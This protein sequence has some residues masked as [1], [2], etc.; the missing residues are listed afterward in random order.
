MLLLVVKPVEKTM[1]KKDILNHLENLLLSQF[2]IRVVYEN[3][4]SQS[5]RRKQGLCRC[6]DEYLFIINEK[7]KTDY[8]IAAI[9]E[10]LTNFDLESIYLPPQVRKI[11][12]KNRKTG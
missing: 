5:I 2:D 9:C 1:K 7:E 12:D 4:L 6:D 8:K 10:I 3:L 11:I